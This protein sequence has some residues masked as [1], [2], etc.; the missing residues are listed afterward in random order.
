MALLDF[1]K[2]TIGIDP[3]SQHLRIVKDGELV[4]NEASRI[5]FDK[6]THVVTGIGNSTSLTDQDV[7]IKPVDCAIADFQGFE[8]LL[9]EAMKK[10]FRSKSIIPKSY[11]MYYCIPTSTTE[12]EKRSYRDSA[13]HAGA[14]EAYMIYQS[15]CAAIG[16]NI[17]LEQKDFILVDFGHSKIETTVFVNSLPISIGVIRMG[18]SKIYSLLKNFLKR[19]YKIIVT[20]QEVDFMLTALKKNDVE[21]RIKDASVKASEMQDL[22]E[23]FFIIVNDEFMAAIELVSGRSDIE[24]AITAGIYFTGGGSAIDSLRDKITADN[25]IK[26]TVSQN[27]LLDNINGL[28]KI[29]AD[30]TRFSKYIMV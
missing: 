22:L 18:T 7:I 8:M 6:T 9:R 14:V 4:F 17:L 28:K 13:E 3:G 2:D 11:K 25:R 1:L 30:S 24:K 23:N 26:R 5:S 29:M 15:C 21:I 10:S 20:D 27:P 16:L 19:R 12:V